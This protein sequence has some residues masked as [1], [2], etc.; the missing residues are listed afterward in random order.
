MQV[1]PSLTFIILKSRRRKY[2][3]DEIKS[4]NNRTY[5]NRNC[6][7]NNYEIFTE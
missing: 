7:D 1:L 2:V 4:I 3:C 5:I 6:V